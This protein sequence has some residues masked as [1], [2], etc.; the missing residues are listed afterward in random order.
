MG[1]PE[2]F[3]NGS[4]PPAAIHDK[5]QVVKT[6]VL[7]ASHVLLL[8]SLQCTMSFLD[9]VQSWCSGVLQVPVAG[10]DTEGCCFELFKCRLPFL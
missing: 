7:R 3:N 1:V 2:G 4:T 8:L 6:C 5:V 10:V 9:A